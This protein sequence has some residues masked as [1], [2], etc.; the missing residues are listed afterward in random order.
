MS[1]VKELLRVTAA[2]GEGRVC[3]V[4]V[5]TWVRARRSG[6]HGLIPE[7]STDFWR[8]NVFLRGVHLELDYCAP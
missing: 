2:P 4:K 7:T 5:I 1:A 8:D 3:L 6:S